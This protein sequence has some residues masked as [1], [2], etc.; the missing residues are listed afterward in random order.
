LTKKPAGPREDRDKPLVNRAK[1]GD[2]DALGELF[3]RHSPA[4]RRLLAS[5]IGPTDELDD[6]VQEVFIQVHRSLPGFRGD[7][8]FSTWLHQVTVYAAYNFL[9]RPRRR[10]VPT[11]PS[12]LS[13]ISGP[14]GESPHAR[15]FGRE[16]LRRLHAILD[17]IKPKKRIAFI[18]FAV[19]GLSVGEVAEVVNAP[20]PTVK[21]RIWFARRELKK[22]ARRDP[23][24][25]QLLEELGSDGL[26]EK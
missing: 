12:R 10:W 7:A 9:R 11:E 3:V 20:V 4:V 19:H 8:L 13:A 18:L 6:L 25:S 21:S 15:L 24:L 22:K 2:R 14:S 17:T 1:R 5:V 23:Y 26:D 16:T